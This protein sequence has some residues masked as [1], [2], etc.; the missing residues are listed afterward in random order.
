LLRKLDKKCA[1]G[2]IANLLNM[3]GFNEQEI[4]LFW[5][6]SCDTVG[7]LSKCLGEV[8]PKN[9]YKSDVVDSIQQSLW[10]LRKKFGFNTTS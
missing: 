1:E 9:I 7:N 4:D 6:L 10:I 8:I 2:A 5:N 3:L